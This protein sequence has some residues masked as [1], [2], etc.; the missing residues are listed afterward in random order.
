[1]FKR[2][3]VA[4]SLIATAFSFQAPAH[5]NDSVVVKFGNGQG[6]HR[7]TVHRKKF[8]K[9]TR[10]V[11]KQRRAFNR[12]V[13]KPVYK[14]PVH[15]KVY[16]APVHKKFVHH[17]P[18]R[19]HKFRHHRLSN[20]QLRHHLRAKGLFNIRFVDRHHGVAKVVAHNHNGYIARYRVSTR[21]GHI[22]SGRVIRH[23]RRIR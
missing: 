17:A 19:S 11:H 14:A 20:K 3:L 9:P 18:K 6:V 16:K 4:V 22:L 13:H 5:A 1:M 15:K 7:G 10:K 12:P 8:H 21:N 23:T 2:L